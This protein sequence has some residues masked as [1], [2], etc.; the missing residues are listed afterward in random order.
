MIYNMHQTMYYM[1]NEHDFHDCVIA[2]DDIVIWFGY[3]S[4]SDEAD[5]LFDLLTLFYEY[6]VDY[7]ERDSVFLSIQCT[8][9]L[10]EYYRKENAAANDLFNFIKSQVQPMDVLTR[11]LDLMRC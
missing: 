7:I 4:E 11:Q 1:M 6:G 8:M 3:K 9:E 10:S 5:R 2:F